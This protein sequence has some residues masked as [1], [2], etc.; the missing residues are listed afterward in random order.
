MN[1]FNNQWLSSRD[2]NLFVESCKVPDLATTFGTPLFV[3][4]E[5]GV[6]E[7]FRALERAFASHWPE[8]SVRIMP[9]F[10][11]APL[12]AVRRILSEEGAGCDVFGPGE[13][14]GALRA[15]VPP[16]MI[17]L[18]GSIKSQALVDQAVALGS[19]IVLDSIRDLERCEQ[20]AEKAGK[21]A[22]VMLRL[23]PYLSGLDNPSDFLPN[24]TIRELTQTIKY[25]IPTSEV[26]AMLPSLRANRQIELTGVHIHMG[27]HSKDLNVWRALVQAY[28][29]L[30]KRISQALDGWLPSEVDFGGGIAALNDRET[31][32]AVTDYATPSWSSYAEVLTGSFRDAMDAVSLPTAG[33][34]IEVEPGRAL[35]NET[36]IHL[37]TVHNLKQENEEIVRCWVEVDTSEVFLGVVGLPSE[38]PPFDFVVANRLDQPGTQV[39]DIVGATCNAEWLCTQAELPQMVEG[40]VI[41]FLNT[42]S[43]IEPMAANF[44]ALPRPGTVLVHGDKAEMIKQH[45]SIEQVFSRD[46]IPERLQRPDQT[47]QKIQE[48][49]D[50]QKTT[51]GY[52]K[53][54]VLP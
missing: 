41:A 19:R 36:G 22:Q 39:A 45:E 38:T 5:Q 1:P 4:S 35:H 32:V 30:I 6:R 48:F 34:T 13:Y 40:D 14:S 50:M 46:L 33:I 53:V 15:G 47:E 8:G 18:N 17:S 20:A 37:S 7:N 28:V 44:N 10:K 2:G 3:V 23:K 29:G 21:P 51:D 11:A 25:G 26:M 12:L 9:A 42:G 27:R 49:T 16:A 31:R 43:Y 54:V 52:C 24:H